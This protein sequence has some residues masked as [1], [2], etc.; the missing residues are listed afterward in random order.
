[1]LL[2]QGHTPEKALSSAI[3]RVVHSPDQVVTFYPGAEAFAD[4]SR[5]AVEELGRRLGE[6]FP[7]IQVDVVHGGQPHYHYLASVE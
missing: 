3:D 4:A 2:A 5:E 6:A 7:G 1:M